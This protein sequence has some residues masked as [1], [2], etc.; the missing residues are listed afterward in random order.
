MPLEERKML[1]KIYK[2]ADSLTPIEIGLIASIAWV[3]MLYLFA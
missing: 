1:K 3:G 2:A